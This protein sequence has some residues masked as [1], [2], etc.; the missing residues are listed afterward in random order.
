M[1]SYLNFQDLDFIQR[2]ETKYIPV[3]KIK[4]KII[5]TNTDDYF[6]SNVYKSLCTHSGLSK[7]KLEGITYIPELFINSY[8]SWYSSVYYINNENMK[9]N[10]ENECEQNEKEST[11]ELLSDILKSVIVIKTDLANIQTYVSKSK[12][13]NMSH[14]NVQ[15]DN[16][17]KIGDSMEPLASKIQANPMEVITPKLKEGVHKIQEI[18]DDIFEDLKIKK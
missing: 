9:M 12:S 6:K 18:K 8:A 7:I 13:S 17:N 3:N 4:S 16:F 5:I 1:H 14:K 2:N 10:L 11:N 15:A